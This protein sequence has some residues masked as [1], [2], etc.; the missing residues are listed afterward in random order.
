M[1]LFLQSVRLTQAATGGLN[2]RSLAFQTTQ[3][4]LPLSLY[5]HLVY[6]VIQNSPSMC[7]EICLLV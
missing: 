5:S 7:L 6:Y 2:P 4:D 3:P 1:S